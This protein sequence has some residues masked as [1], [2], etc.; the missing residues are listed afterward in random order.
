LFTQAISRSCSCNGCIPISEVAYLLIIINFETRIQTIPPTHPPTK[1]QQIPH[2]K[3][4]RK[5][6]QVSKTKNN[7]T[8]QNK[9]K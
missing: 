9:I 4:K 6:R 3:T 2:T 1:T 7:A 8:L 5:K